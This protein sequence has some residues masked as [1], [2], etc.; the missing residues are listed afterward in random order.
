MT[1]TA[2][3]LSTR[4][5]DHEEFRAAFERLQ[6]V[7]AEKTRILSRL[8]AING[9]VSRPSN[10][11]NGSLSDQAAERFLA[12]GELTAAATSAV[13]AAREEA[14]TLY[15]QLPVINRAAELQ[16]KRL[17]QIKADIGARIAQKL[18]PEYVE[19]LKRLAAAVH[20]AAEI[21]DEERAFRAV[22][23]DQQIPFSGTFSACP[24][25]EGFSLESWS[26]VS[27]WFA[28]ISKRFPGEINFS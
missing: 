7:R 16:E 28:E 21:A 15:A 3:N 25:P 23:I 14:E 19:L 12:G 4:L 24:L 5:E 8:D 2:E 1:T 10:E 20:E 13:A 18:R 17:A 6:R 22:L 11:K 26:F 27:Q 9:L